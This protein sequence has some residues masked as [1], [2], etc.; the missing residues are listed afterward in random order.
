MNSELSDCGLD[1]KQ[2]GRT[3][4]NRIYIWAGNSVGRVLPLQGRSR[5]FES[6]QVHQPRRP[7]KSD[8]GT[9]YRKTGD[10]WSNSSLIGTI[11]HLERCIQN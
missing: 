4:S 5:E 1:E 10:K 11:L 3:T 2:A 6:H 8:A 7:E 9:R